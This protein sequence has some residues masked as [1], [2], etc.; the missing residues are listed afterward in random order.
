MSQDKEKHTHSDK[1]DRYD[2]DNDDHQARSP[3]TGFALIVGCGGEL[4]VCIPHVYF[5]G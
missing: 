2:N 1:N 4:A 5:Y 3:L